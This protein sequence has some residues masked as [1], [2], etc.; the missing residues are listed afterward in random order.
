MV[1]L[2]TRGRQ[3]IAT[4]SDHWI[5]LRQPDLVIRQVQTVVNTIRRHG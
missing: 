1:K 4:Q 3:V 2:S 5:Q